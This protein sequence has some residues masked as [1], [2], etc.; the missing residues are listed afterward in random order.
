MFKKLPYWLRGGCLLVLLLVILDGIFIFLMRHPQYVGSRMQIIAQ[1]QLEFFTFPYYI[2][3]L[4]GMGSDSLPL[5]AMVI[6]AVVTIGIYFCVGAMIGTAYDKTKYKKTVIGVVVAA[7]LLIMAMQYSRE[8]T[9]YD[10]YFPTGR[11]PQECDEMQDPNAR[12]RCY[13]GIYRLLPP[14]ASICTKIDVN[15]TPER[16]ECSF[17]VGEFAKDK[18]AC[19][20]F[21]VKDEKDECLRAV[22]M[23]TLDES[24]CEL[25]AIKPYLEF[26]KHTGRD[27]CYYEIALTKRDTSLCP[28]IS[29]EDQKQKCKQSIQQP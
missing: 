10:L 13:A 17:A 26:A 9:K 12:G 29:N 27:S 23:V 22:A 6:G 20:M 28:K 14:D 24:L 15:M 5:M 4:S 3:A 16:Q 1:D 11:T 8:R 18:S 2:A 19:D 21:D 25:L 7:L